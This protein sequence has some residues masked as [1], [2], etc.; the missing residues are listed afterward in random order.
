MSSVGTLSPEVL[1]PLGR[2]L[3]LGS[4]GI[5]LVRSMRRPFELELTFERLV[6]AVLC[7]IFFERAA[8]LL[9]VVSD[10]MADSISKLGDRGELK[11]LILEAFRRS[12]GEPGPNGEETSFNLPAVLE[13]AWRTGVWGVMAMIV[14]WCFLIVSF[15]LESARGVF[16]QLVLFL[17]PLACGVYPVFPRILTNLAIYAVE[18][19]LWFPVLA[20]VELTT[21]SV[22]RNAMLR[23]DSAGMHAVSVELL[24]IIL[25][26]LI[27]AVTHKFLSGAFSGDF[28]SQ[29]SLLRMA[30]K[31]ILTAK[32]WSAKL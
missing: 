29:A 31:A 1:V 12:A 14:D 9:L 4:L 17:F 27:P 25:I 15:L 3:L 24:A 11:A 30:R 19:A 28:G 7:L 16:W 10:E 23:S 13:Q 18:L 26:L 32:P 5:S 2:I 20:L 8:A 22:A 21:S 6:V